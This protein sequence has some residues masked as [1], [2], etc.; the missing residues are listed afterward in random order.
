[1][2]IQSEADALFMENFK[3]ATIAD[4]ERGIANSERWATECIVYLPNSAQRA[5][6]RALRKHAEML[7]Q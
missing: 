6:Y 5:Q 1:M 4:L 2:S 7:R 3:S